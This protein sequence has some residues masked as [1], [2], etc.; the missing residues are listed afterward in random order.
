MQT[1]LTSFDPFPY[2]HC[3]LPYAVRAALPNHYVSMLVWTGARRN[4][5]AAR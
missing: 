3:M 5:L 1:V 2:R 4:G